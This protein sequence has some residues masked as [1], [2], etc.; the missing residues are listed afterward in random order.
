MFWIAPDGGSAQPLTRSDSLQFPWSFT[1]DGRHLAFM[2]ARRGTTG[3][4]LWTVD[5]DRVGA[6][7]RAGGARPVTEAD[8][9]E[10]HPAFSADGRWLAYTSNASGSFQVYV[11]P[12][13]PTAAARGLQISSTGGV[14]PE[15]LPGGSLLVWRT[16]DNVLMATTYSVDGDMF[17]ADKPHVWST[18]RLAD[19]G[20]TLNFDVTSDRRRLVALM[21]EGPPDE[22]RHLT[23][24]QHFLDELRRTVR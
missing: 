23:F 4:R 5:V 22:R 6:A 11:R 9:D 7:L 13:P 20:L 15:F 8:V 21:P 18:A 19:I 1:P 16:E 2:E 14:Y 24:F 12:F 10:R 17:V 3:Y